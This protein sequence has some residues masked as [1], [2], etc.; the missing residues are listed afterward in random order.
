MYDNSLY[1]ARIADE[2]TDIL[3]RLGLEGEKFVLAT[4]HRDNNTDNPE[5]LT[6]ITE[7]LLEITER[8]YKIVLLLNLYLMYQNRLLV[9]RIRIVLSI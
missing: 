5:R 7:S 3:R 6:A 9:L 2:K 4:I 1:F 8:G